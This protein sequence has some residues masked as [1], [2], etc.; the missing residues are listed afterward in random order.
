MLQPEWLDN[1]S[2]PFESKYFALPEG[3]MH[4][5]LE[6]QGE[7]MVMVHGTPEWSFVYRELI[8][9]FRTEFCCIASDHLGFGLSDK[10]DI[11]YA[12]EAQAERL[13]RFLNHLDLKN[14]TLV[15]HDFG[16]PIGLAYA[17]KY[18]EKIKRIIIMNSWLWS[19]KK[20]PFYGL[21]SRL[22][23][24]PLG[25]WL[26]LKQ[27]F[28]AKV[29]MKSAFAD[30]TKLTSALHR[31]YLRALPDAKSRKAT[32]DYAKSFI[33]SDTWF[34]SLWHNRE[35]LKAIPA[36][37]IW[38]MKDIA[39]KPKDLYKFQT[40]FNQFEICELDVGHFPQEETPED[41]LK[42]IAAFVNETTNKEVENVH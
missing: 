23:T 25:N 41:V 22:M 16:G 10:P 42:A 13:E 15:V 20:D 21:F 14:I 39:F 12:P 37:F 35:Q 26:Y 36:L 29:I 17:Q 30:K 27:G 18:P 8:K 7:P 2:Y 1:A 4:Y 32:L 19:V 38:G 33:S 40:I 34:A 3:Q 24:T 9:A 5:V 6:G 31:H 11:S 28:S